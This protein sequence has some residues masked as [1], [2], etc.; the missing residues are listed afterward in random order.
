[1]CEYTLIYSGNTGILESA[2]CDWEAAFAK[3]YIASPQSVVLWE[4]ICYN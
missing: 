3:K 4:T 1:M 2:V